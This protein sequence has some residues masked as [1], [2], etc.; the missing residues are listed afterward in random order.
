MSTSVRPK[1]SYYLKSKGK[2]GKSKG[3]TKK[4]QVSTF[5]TFNTALKSNADASTVKTN[6]ILKFFDA[7]SKLNLSTHSKE[8]LE[9]LERSLEKISIANDTIDFRE[10]SLERESVEDAEGVQEEAKSVFG[11]SKESV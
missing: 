9:P 7:E 8:L 11:A 10:P 4:S 5:K 1:S 6:D 2:S 3:T